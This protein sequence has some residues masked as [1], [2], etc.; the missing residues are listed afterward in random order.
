M[1]YL[2]YRLLDNEF[3]ALFLPVTLVNIK[4]IVEIRLPCTKN[5]KINYKE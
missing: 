2:S 1:A 3:I 4:L 5:V